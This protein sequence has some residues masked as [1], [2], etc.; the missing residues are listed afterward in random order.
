MPADPRLSVLLERFT[1][2]GLYAVVQSTNGSIPDADIEMTR[3]PV[4]QSN[5]RGA[6]NMRHGKPRPTRPGTSRGQSRL[7]S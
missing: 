4:R 7:G 1:P 6:G 3:P 2:K 5:R